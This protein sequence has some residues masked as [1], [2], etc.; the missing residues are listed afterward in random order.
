MK[1]HPKRTTVEFMAGKH[2]Y[3]GACG[4]KTEWQIWTR[5]VRRYFLC[6]QCQWDIYGAVDAFLEERRKRNEE[7]DRRAAR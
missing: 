4:C 1:R 3:C 7:A 2:G 6:L 5:R